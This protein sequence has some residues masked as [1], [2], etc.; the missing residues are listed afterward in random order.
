MQLHPA[1]AQPRR[2]IDPI[3]RK[4]GVT[5]IMKS[6]CRAGLLA[7]ALTLYHLALPNLAAAEDA[8]TNLAGPDQ[9]AIRQVIEAQLD[10]F[11]HDD[12]AKAF[13]YATPTIQQKFGDPATFMQMVKS[14]YTAV[15][16]PRSVAFEKLVDTQQGPDQIL[17]L[18]GPDGITYAAHYL[19]QKQAD[20]SWMI[21]G[22]YLTRLED[23]NV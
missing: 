19:M 17:R 9:A 1:Q 6:V 3:R 20:G 5:M 13:G 18:V 15:Y 4:Q 21:N 16:R 23:Q 14:G 2:F 10:A 7:I 22:C 12:G 11:Q 8:P